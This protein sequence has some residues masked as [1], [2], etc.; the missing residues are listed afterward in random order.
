MT[1]EHLDLLRIFFKQKGFVETAS[2]SKDELFFE[3]GELRTAVLVV[4]SEE[5]RKKGEALKKL[6]KASSLSDVDYVYIA[7]SRLM[8]TTIDTS[9]LSQHGL[10]L[11]VVDGRVI[12]ALPAKKRARQVGLGE[13]VE[14]IAM[15]EAK[16]AELASGAQIAMATPSGLE[17]VRAQLA[18]LRA[19]LDSSTKRLEAS[20]NSLAKR[21]AKLEEGQA[22]RAVEV[23]VAVEEPQKV[24]VE[25]LPSYFKDNPWIAILSSRG[26]RD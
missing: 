22:R 12:E 24:E 21:V 10:G 15:L 3:K 9:A 23:E 14:R 19:R 11:L 17:E 20:I 25:G 8:A 26:R 1:E 4:S 7:T 6:L 16:V 5:L 18:E 13:L 2:P